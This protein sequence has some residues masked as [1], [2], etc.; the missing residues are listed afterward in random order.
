MNFKE[1][2]LKI[3]TILSEI[4]QEKNSLII[5]TNDLFSFIDPEFFDES[6]E[7]DMLVSNQIKKRTLVIANLVTTRIKQELEE[8]E[9]FITFETM[10]FD[11]QNYEP[12]IYIYGYISDKKSKFKKPPKDIKNNEEFFISLDFIKGF[13][14]LPWS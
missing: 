10:K 11:F 4:Y 8:K 9:D 3:E 13:Q 14:L 12:I 1:N 2:K 5:K 6:Y 7:E